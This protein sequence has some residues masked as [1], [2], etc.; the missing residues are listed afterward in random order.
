MRLTLFLTILV[1]LLSYLTCKNIQ[2]T[3]I[4]P[5]TQSTPVEEEP[6]NNLPWKASHVVEGNNPDT[7]F[8]YQAKRAPRRVEVPWKS[9]P[10]P[11]TSRRAYLATGW[12]NPIMAF[13][14]SDTTVHKQFLGKSLKFRE[15]QTFDILEGK[16][17]VDQGNWA[18]D[19]VKKEIYISCKNP[20]F[21]NTWKVQENGYRMVWIGNTEL[22]LTGIQVRFDDYKTPPGEGQ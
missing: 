7:A 19:D 6:V 17:V 20:Y 3:Q 16:K 22:N 18:Y 5:S 21:N 8:T 14:G 10:A 9:V 11:S 12:W 2:K 13:Q 1:V 15:D 4:D